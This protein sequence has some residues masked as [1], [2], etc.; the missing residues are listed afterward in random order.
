MDKGDKVK[1]EIILRG[2][3]RRHGDLATKVIKKFIEE[4]NEEVPIKVEQPVTRQGGQ[5]T[6]IVGKA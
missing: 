1:I 5:L 4:L 2:R 6:T 3:E